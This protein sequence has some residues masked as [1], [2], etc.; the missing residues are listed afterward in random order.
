MKGTRFY[1]LYYASATIT[2]PTFSAS[3]VVEIEIL[4]TVP[5]LKVHI[6]M[7]HVKES[8]HVRWLYYTRACTRRRALQGS[9]RS[10]VYN[11][12]GSLRVT[13]SQCNDYKRLPFVY[14]YVVCV[15]AH[16]GIC[17]SILL[18]PCIA[19]SLELSSVIATPSPYFLNII[20]PCNQTNLSTIHTMH[21]T[22]YVQSSSFMM[23]PIQTFPSLS[24]LVITQRFPISSS[25]CQTNNP[26]NCLAVTYL[27]SFLASHTL[28]GFPHLKFL[29]LDSPKVGNLLLNF[30]ISES[31]CF[32]KR[33][34]KVWGQQEW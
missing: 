3:V 6:R 13:W 24:S 2:P 8:T 23:Y 33:T 26:Q 7:T 15:L 10:F 32:F 27:Q 25:S 18:L 12:T 1:L 9:M 34:E 22:L 20:W 14:V 21:S 17:R 28:G 16:S 5:V 30:L 29:H 31:L 4:L 11:S 19:H